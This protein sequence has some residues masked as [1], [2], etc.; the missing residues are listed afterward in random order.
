[1]EENQERCLKC[2][3]ITLKELLKMIRVY[4]GRKIT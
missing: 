2:G 1:M 4:E 3:D